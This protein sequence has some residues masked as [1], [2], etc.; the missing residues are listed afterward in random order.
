MQ[1]AAGD[2]QDQ[3]EVKGP[4]YKV[5]PL[6]K[7]TARIPGAEGRGGGGKRPDLSLY[8]SREPHTTSTPEHWPKSAPWPHIT[9]PGIPGNAAP[10]LLFFL[11]FLI[12]ITSLYSGLFSP[13]GEM[14]Q[15]EGNSDMVI[16]LKN[17]VFPPIL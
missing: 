5:H 1:L 2:P 12:S 13:V 14:E 4:R 3:E 16:G 9:F 15:I 17:T 10:A 7:I 6:S 8:V 11:S